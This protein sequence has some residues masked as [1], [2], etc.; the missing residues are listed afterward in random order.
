MRISRSLESLDLI[1]ELAHAFHS[2]FNQV[3][4]MILDSGKASLYRC[5]ACGD[6]IAAHKVR[7]QCQTCP[8]YELCADCAILGSATGYH[9]FTHETTLHRT[10]GQAPQKEQ[11]SR[12]PPALAPGKSTMSRPPLPPKHQATDSF[13]MQSVSHALPQ[14]SSPAPRVKNHSRDLEEARQAEELRRAEKELEE[15]EERYK[16]E[17]EERRIKNDLEYSRALQKMSEDNMRSADRSRE[18]MNQIGQDRNYYVL[19]RERYYG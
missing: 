7:V 8:D 9:S 10:S 3:S 13:R 12:L 4:A 5:S 14:P 2:L 18:V 15:L 1:F 19:E 11:T 6:A 17:A 16:R